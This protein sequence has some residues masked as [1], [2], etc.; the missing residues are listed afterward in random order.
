MIDKSLVDDVAGRLDTIFTVAADKVR[1]ELPELADADPSAVR[2]AVSTVFGVVLSAL[3]Q[4]RDLGPGELEKLAGTGEGAADRGQPLDLML[5]VARLAAWS[6]LDAL[7]TIA[8]EHGVSVG[9]RYELVHDYW[10]RADLALF[11]FAAGHH[12]RLLELTR[13]D[14]KRRSD[15]IRRLLHGTIRGAELRRHAHQHGLDTEAPYFAVRAR[16][17]DLSAPHLIEHAI[18]TSGADAGR[19]T[20]LD[21]IDGDVAGVTARVP[22]APGHAHVGVSGPVPLAGLAEAFADASRALETAIAFDLP[23]PVRPE[24]HP[25][26]L[27][28]AHD[29]TVGDLAEQRCFGALDERSQRSLSVEKTLRAFLDAELRVDAAAASL[30]L[31]PNTLRY[32]IGRIEEATGLRLTRLRDTF[33]V[34]WALQ[35]RRISRRT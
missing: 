13:Q 26:E 7:E 34:W 11:A 2:G 25:L 12:R 8:V 24:D 23:D 17:A 30:H 5:Q 27:A 9:T 14:E 21:V 19:R 10:R 20:L 4:R 3:A 16:P 32:R 31:H 15:F 18:A 1:A 29:H 35:H 6:V 22:R 33:L 28:V